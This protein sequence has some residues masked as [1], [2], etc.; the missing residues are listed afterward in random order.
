MVKAWNDM[1]AA[2]GLFSDEGGQFVG[3]YGMLA[4]NKLKTV[5]CL[6]S[7]WDGKPIVHQRAI[8]GTVIHYGKRL[9]LRE[10]RAICSP[11]LS[12]RIR[13]Y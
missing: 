3:G 1:H 11:I 2:L 13:E 12:C 8:D 5:A 4:E 10:A 6:S 7:L 9:A